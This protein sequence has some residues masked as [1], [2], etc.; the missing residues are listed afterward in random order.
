MSVAENLLTAYGVIALA[1]CF[2][3]VTQSILSGA[4]R[5][6]REGARLAFLAPVWP[7]LL[8]IGIR[9][10]WRTADWSRR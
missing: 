8:L 10:L 4:A 9:H 6:R 2:G 7:V 5:D 1:V 3:G